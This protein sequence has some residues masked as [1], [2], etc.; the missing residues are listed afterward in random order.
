MDEITQVEENLMFDDFEGTDGYRWSLILPLMVKTMEVVVVSFR[1]G[2]DFSE[3]TWLRMKL[4]VWFIH[5]QH[6]KHTVEHHNR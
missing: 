1:S 3:Y 5:S 4:P 2:S 6:Q